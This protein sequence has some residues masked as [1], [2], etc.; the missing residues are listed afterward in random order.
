M[1]VT[2]RASPNPHIFLLCI[3]NIIDTV[4]EILIVVW[5]Q[6]RRELIGY[7]VK[8]DLHFKPYF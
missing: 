7:N 2:T 5:L 3:S 8:G 6:I 1:E 4:L